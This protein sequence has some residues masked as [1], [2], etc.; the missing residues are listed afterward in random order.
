[1]VSFS[2]TIGTTPAGEHRLHAVALVEVLAPRGEAL[3]GG[4]HL[5][6]DD[7]VFVE[8][9][10]VAVRAVSPARRP[11]RAGA[12][13]R[14]RCVRPGVRG[15][16]RAP[17]GHGPRRDEDH[18]DARAVAALRSGPRAPR[19]AWCRA[20]PSSRV[21]TLLPILMTMRRYF[22]DSQFIIH[23]SQLLRPDKLV[24]LRATS[25]PPSRHCEERSDAAIRSK[26]VTSQRVQQIPAS[27]L[28]PSSE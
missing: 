23:D 22:F 16:P 2:L 19:C 26:V 25:P 20:V 7:A 9:V 15:T 21:S 6:A 28:R 13:K 17:D 8:E 5:P 12:P 3:L 4:E 27:V 10:V 11:R 1:M 14:C 18:L 24:R